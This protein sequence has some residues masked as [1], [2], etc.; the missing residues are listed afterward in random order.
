M[1]DGVRDELLHQV[2]GRGR[3]GHQVCQDPGQVL[4]RGMPDDQRGEGDDDVNDED[5]QDNMFGW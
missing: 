2:Q 3:A 4:R 1:Q 5:V